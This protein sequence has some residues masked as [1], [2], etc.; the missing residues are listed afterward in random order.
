MSLILS[1]GSP[2][3]NLSNGIHDCG[4]ATLDLGGGDYLISE[5]LIVPLYFG[6][7][8]IVDGTLRATETFAP[9]TSY[10]LIIGD[11]SNAKCS[12]SQGSCNENVGVENMMFDCR[13]ICHGG[14]HVIATMGCVIG[15]QMFFLGFNGAGVTVSG[16][17]ETMIFTAWFGEFLYSD[18]RKENGTASTATG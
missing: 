9:S 11:N 6:N 18:S 2:I 8:R 12:N 1:Y 4:G 17:H 14:I 3:A 15:P 7:L 13:Q 5:P 16:G 10:L